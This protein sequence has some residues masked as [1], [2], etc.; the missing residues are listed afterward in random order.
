MYPKAISLTS[1]K[2]M[3]EKIAVFHNYRPTFMKKVRLSQF[4]FLENF[5]DK[6]NMTFDKGRHQS[7]TQIRY[8]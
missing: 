3:C 4:L 2:K 6:T 8:L 1:L 5:Q 7:L